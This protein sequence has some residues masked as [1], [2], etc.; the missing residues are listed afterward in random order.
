MQSPLMQIAQVDAADGLICAERREYWA[1]L[2]DAGNVARLVMGAG[3][4]G[5]MR[6]VALCP[7][8]RG[9][10]YAVLSEADH[11]SFVFARADEAVRAWTEVGFRREPIYVKDNADGY[12]ILA[13]LLPSLRAARDGL[14]R[15]VIHDE[16]DAWWGRLSA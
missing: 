10:L 6:L 4:E 12:R 7:V 15:R 9:E 2:R 11:A 3:S 8:A 5:S 13:G 16:P 14:M 1:R